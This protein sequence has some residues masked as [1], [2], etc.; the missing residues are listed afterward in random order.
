MYLDK[1]RPLLKNIVLMLWAVALLAVSAA[2][3]DSMTATT[4][5]DSNTDQVLIQSQVN[6]LDQPL[7]AAVPTGQK[8]ASFVKKTVSSL[9]Y[10]AYKL[11]GTRFD[12]ASGVY[13]IDCS[14]YVDQMLHTVSPKAYSSLV[15]ST[16][17]DHP[18]SRTYYDFF[19][20][21]SSAPKTYW[22]K[23]KSV[24][25]LQP[26]D[27]LVFCYKHMGDHKA[28]G[29]V[30]IVVGKPVQQG[31]KYVVSVADSAAAAH[32]EDTRSKNG[33]GIGKMALKVEPET[34]KPVAYAWKESSGWKD[35]VNFAMARPV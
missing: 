5:P 4:V 9:K 10:S 34:G 18:T 31:D 25:Q 14:S 20:S 29:H 2:F 27:I 6:T 28:A 3:F 33:V 26:G 15:N 21:L 17:T 11:G 7:V 35:N 16:G 32:S 8:L 30:M 22:D 24:R 19:N 23:I 13:I 1:Q 12:L